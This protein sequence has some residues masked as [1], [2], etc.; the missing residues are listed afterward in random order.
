MPTNSIGKCQDTQQVELDSSQKDDLDSTPH[1]PHPISAQN[2]TKQH[3]AEGKMSSK[4]DVHITRQIST[5]GLGVGG[6]SISG[7]I[8]LERAVLCVEG[9]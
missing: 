3:K 6:P 5:P 2:F 7:V 4:G 9:Y 8:G 1:P